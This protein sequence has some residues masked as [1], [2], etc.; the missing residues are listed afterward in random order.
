MSFYVRCHTCHTP[1]YEKGEFLDEVLNIINQGKSEEEKNK[2][3][4]QL[5]DKYGYVNMC[6]RMIALGTISLHRVIKR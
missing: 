1:F 5:L 6:C 3:M 4:P 2:L